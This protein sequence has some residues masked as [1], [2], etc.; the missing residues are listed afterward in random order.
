VCLRGPNRAGRQHHIRPPY[1]V[2]PY[3]HQRQPLLVTDYTLFRMITNVNQPAQTIIASRAYTSNSYVYLKMSNLGWP[4]AP[5]WATLSCVALSITTSTAA[6]DRLYF[7]WDRSKGKSTGSDYHLKYGVHDNIVCVLRRSNLGLAPP[8]HLTTISYVAL[9]TSA[10]TAACDRLYFV[11]DRSK[12][13]STGSDHHLMYGGHDNI[14]CVLRRSNLG[15][16][17]PPHWT[18]ISYLALSTSTS[19]T[20]S[21]RLYFVWDGNKGKSTGSDHPLFYK[22]YYNLVCVLRRSN[23]G[24]SPAPHWATM[25]CVVLSTSASTAASDQLFCSGSY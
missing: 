5:H 11:W 9:S 4:P 7:V 10:S 21:D 20:A 24:L 2:Q 6:G 15:L 12:G 25:S 19:T 16:A 8:P 17:P 23:L 3:P 22:R 18:T 1:R 14:V 13:K